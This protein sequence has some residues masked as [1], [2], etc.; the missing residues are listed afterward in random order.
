MGSRYL[1]HSTHNLYFTTTTVVGWVD[2][3]T[4]QIYRDILY[5]SWTYCREK[6]GLRIH[7]YVIMTNHIHMIVSSEEVPLQ[8]IFRD[9]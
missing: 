5:Q 7:A 8:G 6:K 4:R 9:F 3:F 2:I 1:L